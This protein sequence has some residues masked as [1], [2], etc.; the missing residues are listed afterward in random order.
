MD[1]LGSYRAVVIAYAVA[2]L[3][4]C[5]L[6]A[7]LSSAVEVSRSRSTSSQDS[8]GMPARLRGLRR[9]KRVVLKLLALFSLDAFAVGFVLQSM[10]AYWFYV[11]FHVQLAF[12]GSVFFGANVL[13]GVS[14]LTA[15]RSAD[16]IGLVRTMIFTHI[17]SNILLILVPLMPNLRLAIA[18][19][20]LR[21]SISQMDVPTRQ[22][23]TMAIVRPDERAAA[24]G[25][26]G[27]AR[28]TQASLSP[29]MAGP[30]LAQASLLN[31]PFFLAGG[32]KII[33][34]LLLYKSFRS[35]RPPEETGDAGVTPGSR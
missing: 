5:F 28:T 27:I 30:L 34:D 14:P 33:Y 23:Y 10:V 15:A 18:I 2:G 25:I 3:I 8:A 13:A 21:F 19:L 31:V 9:S 17:P 11:R 24:A 29:I 32:L 6:F 4:L 16:R 20:L 7:G 35:L 26:T 1:A 12:L 22:S